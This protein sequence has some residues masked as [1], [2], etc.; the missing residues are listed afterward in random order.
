M[1]T[2]YTVE[3]AAS[4]LKVTALTVRRWLKSGELRGSK[5]GGLWR[6]KESDIEAALK[7]ET[8]EG[9]Q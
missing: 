7:I 5:I 1:E 3:E 9:E 8:Q 4:M 2:L 6:I